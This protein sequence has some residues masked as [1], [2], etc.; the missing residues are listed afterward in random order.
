M[1]SMAL[2][3]TTGGEV[4]N[5]PY[6]TAV[7]AGDE[8]IM[9]RGTP[10]VDPARAALVKHLL[11]EVDLDKKHWDKPF[12]RMREDMKMT[13]NTRGEQWD[14]NE[15]KYVANLCARH[16]RERTSALYAKNPRAIAKRRKRLDFAV[17]DG[18]PES[19]QMA[20]QKLQAAAASQLPPPPDVM[21]LIADIETGRAQRA[22]L[23]KVG[24][25]LEILYQ[26][27]VD[28]NEPKF[29]QQAKQLIRRVE[30]CGV[31]YVKLDFQRVME[32]KPDITARIA[33]QT[34]QLSKIQ[35]LSADYADN[36]FSEDDAKAEELKQMIESLR[37]QETIIAREG[38]IFDFPKSTMVIPSRNTTQLTGWV[39][40]DRL[41]EEFRLTRDEIKRIFNVDIGDEF[42]SSSDTNAAANAVRSA[43]G[44]S[45]EKHE[46]ATVYVMQNK[47][48]GLVYVLCE[49]YPDFLK[50]PEP[51]LAKLE[52]FYNIFALC[53][54]ELESEDEIFPPSD[55]R[56]LRHMQKE[57][58]R[59]REALRQHRIANQP[60]NIGAKGVVEEADI[61][62]IRK[63]E[64]HDTL[65]LSIAPG[66][67]P[68]ELFAPVKGAPIDPNLY[69]TSPIFDD[70]E[71]VTG[72]QQAN[73]GGT[74]DSTA[75]EASISEGGRVSSLASN[76]D[77]LDE[78]LSEIA[79]CGG[80]ILLAEMS[81]DQ[82]KKIVGPGAVWP[83]MT[84]DDIIAGISLVV[85]AGSSGRPNKAQDLAN[86]ERAT[87]LLTQT[88]GISPTWIAEKVVELVD[89]TVDLQDALLAG[90]PS[91]VALNAAGPPGAQAQPGTGDPSTDPASQGG[92]GSSNAPSQPERP[93][94][95]QPAYPAPS[96]AVAMAA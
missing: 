38:L 20:L 61:D 21:V 30:E 17:W 42:K 22:M 81:V 88:P 64:P 73:F 55:V 29:K 1:D 24:A 84:R 94:G 14:G 51:P 63:R 37:E 76:T 65:L 48:N 59:S 52:R 56:L 70:I 67:K 43:G 50:E 15:E 68:E 8:S 34:A 33:D 87:P 53:F 26:Y 96:E 2:D 72:S 46:N 7:G 60:F 6:P 5:S 9:N 4:S 3:V 86:M 31:G 62:K 79:D 40:C 82:V 41:T 16:V 32:K 23:D 58:N 80:Q 54:N 13:M 77:D 11:S 44:K 90:A 69:D 35:Q 47:T 27:F 92:A 49:G 78:L 91:L 83:E 93:Q 71:R 36:Q 19:L 45:S 10:V 12:A 39:G 25:T 66:T 57:H 18:K 85:K 28:K 89:D 75:T 74:S 95:P